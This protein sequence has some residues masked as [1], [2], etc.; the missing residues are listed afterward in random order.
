VAKIVS[1]H[2]PLAGARLDY[3]D[4]RQGTGQVF[5]SA[6]GTVA[7]DAAPK[8][9]LRA[10]G[11]EVAGRALVVVVLVPDAARWSSAWPQARALL[12]S[13]RAA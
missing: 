12:T 1:G 5:A 4:V 8:Q 6:N 7:L 3:V 13:M 2:L 9:R 10:I 11:L